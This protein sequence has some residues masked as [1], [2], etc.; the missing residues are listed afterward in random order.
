MSLTKLYGYLSLLLGL[1][2]VITTAPSSF[3]WYN[4]AFSIFETLASK[5]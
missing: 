5:S 4:I 2:F 3:E 1:R